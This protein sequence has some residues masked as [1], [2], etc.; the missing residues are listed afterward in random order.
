MKRIEVFKLVFT[1]FML[2]V[3]CT[4]SQINA[5]N[6]FL[7]NPFLFG[8]NN[9]NLQQNHQQNLQ[10]YQQ[11]LQNIPSFSNSYQQNRP[12]SSSSYLPQQQSTFNFPSD[13]SVSNR[14]PINPQLNLNI[15]I[16]EKKCNEYW[17]N[18]QTSVPVGSLSL[19]PIIQ[20]IQADSCDTSQG[21]IIGGENAKLAEFPHMAALGY[22][23][24]E[25]SF[26]FVCGGSLISD[27]FVLTAAHCRRGGRDRPTLVRLGVLNLK[28]K[29]QYSKEVDLRIQEFIINENYDPNISKNDIAVVKLASK[30]KLSRFIRPACLMN[31][32][33]RVYKDKVIATGWGLTNAYFGETSDVLQKVE[34]S[35]IGNSEC[36]RMLDDQNVDNTQLCAGEDKGEE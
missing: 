14:N 22:K 21:L 11:N 35:V 12:Q 18:S 1:V 9:Q 27:Q 19:N 4:N 25:N 2:S 26:T 36:R 10:N 8:Q 6:P 30:V 16:S 29:E 34:L 31:A 28:I 3:G 23:N 33:E 5:F 20:N 24:L 17:K 15:R 7:N 32:N 13:P